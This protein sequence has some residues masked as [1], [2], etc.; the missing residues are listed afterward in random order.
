MSE[1]FTMKDCMQNSATLHE[2]Q[3]MKQILLDAG[4][5]ANRKIQYPTSHNFSILRNSSVVWRKF[6]K[7]CSEFCLPYVLL[8]LLSP[9]FTEIHFHYFKAGTINC[10]GDP[11][12]LRQ[13][14]LGKEIDKKRRHMGQEKKIFPNYYFSI[15]PPSASSTAPLTYSL[16]SSDSYALFSFLFFFLFCSFSI[17]SFFF[18][19]VSI[20]SFIETQ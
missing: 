19:F 5:E 12:G 14:P 13:Q 7:F 8:I 10:S 1:Y 4:C 15:F 11:Q 2:K 16:Y 6:L 18:L 3:H 20:S 9:I 17:F